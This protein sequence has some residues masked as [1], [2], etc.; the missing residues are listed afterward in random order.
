MPQAQHTFP[1]T[2]VAPGQ[3]VRLVEIMADHQVTHRLAEL[4]LTPG[5]E[6]EIIQDSGGSFLVA[7]RNTRLA[8]RRAIASAILVEST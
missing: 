3:Q 5:V 6:L 1:L 7:V 4:G 2:S 8:L